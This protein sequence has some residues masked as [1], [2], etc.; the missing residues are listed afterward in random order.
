MLTYHIWVKLEHARIV[1]PVSFPTPNELDNPVAIVLDGEQRSA[2]A[3][4]RALGRRGVQV[5]VAGSGTDCLAATS[6]YCLSRLVCPDANAD[7]GAFLSWLRTLPESF[8]NA[9]LMPMGDH[10]TELVIRACGDGLALR[11]ALP[12]QHAYTLASDKL[13]LSHLAE[14][15]QVKAPRTV[16]ISGRDS[17]PLQQTAALRFPLVIKPRVSAIRSQKTGS[18]LAVR[19]ADTPQQLAEILRTQL[20][21]GVDLL[22]QEYVAG[23]GAGVFLLY[24][25]GRYRFSFAHRRLREKPP[26]GGV[27]VLSESAAPEPRHL[28]AARTLLDH[29]AWHGVAM[30]EFKVD[31]DGEP[32]LVEING[33]F[34]GSLQLAVDCGADFPWFFYRLAVDGGDVP[35]PASYPVGRKLRWWLGDLDNLYLRISSATLTPTFA[36]KLRAIAGFAIPWSPGI[37]YEFLRLD[38]PAPAAAALRYYVRALRSHS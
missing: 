2:L 37:R 21:S 22:V 23:T 38:D 8:P 26:T 25:N 13:A 24:E 9:V 11:T 34:W 32:W 19:Y 10:T 3:T 1:T 35:V 31:R 15:L 5:V 30:V 36:A 4:V 20:E 18:K 28:A 17:A 6:R 33:R 29:L 14:K 12:S 27:S 16:L 7:T